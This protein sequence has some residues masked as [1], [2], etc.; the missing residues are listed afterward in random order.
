MYL[1]YFNGNWAEGNAPLFGAMDH[2][3][4]LG[5]SVFDGAR[6]LRGHMPDLRPHLQRVI[7]SAERVGLTCPLSVDE[8][9]KLV[10]EGVAKFPPDAE[11]YIRPLVFGTDGLLIPMPEKS[12]FALTL[13]DAPMPPFTGFSACLSGLRRPDALMAPT[14]AKASSLYA[15]TSKA[16]REARDRGFDNAVVC[17]SAGHVAEFASAN[18]FFVT[19]E[20]KVVTPVANGT[21][22][23]GITRA[24]VIALLAQEGIQVEERSV[25]PEELE[26]AVEIFNTGNYGKVTPCVRYESRTLAV[27]PIATLARDRYM[28]FSDSQ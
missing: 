5:S 25:R 4:W 6:S 22:L 21:F 14:D 16:L 10:R 27:G 2:S 3:V 28:A 17:D 12:A 15:N 9:E 1:T 19:P 18:L 13:F 26:S 11:L 8:M 24:R 7:T 20:G 23:S